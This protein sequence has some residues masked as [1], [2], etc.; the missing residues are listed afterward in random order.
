MRISSTADDI[1]AVPARLRGLAAGLPELASDLTPAFPGMDGQWVNASGRSAEAGVVLY[2]HGGAFADTDPYAEQLMAHWLSKAT[3]RPVF[4]VNYRLAPEHPCPAALD[5]VVAAYR[6]L[7]DRGVPR[8]LLF[9]E[10][11]GATLVLSALLVLKA[12][13]EPVPPAVVVSPLTDLTLSSP[14]L[15]VNDGLDTINRAVLEKVVARY[16]AAS[17]CSPSPRRRCSTPWPAKPATTARTSW[18]PAGGVRVNFG[19]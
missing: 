5:D 9:G 8:C 13:G 15:S 2:V 14:S 12:T 4:V 18:L 16:L 7:L 3:E 10:S 11:A 19:D 17:T 6:S 1:N